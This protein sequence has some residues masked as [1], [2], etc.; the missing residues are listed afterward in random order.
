LNE[1]WGGRAAMSDSRRRCR[2]VMAYHCEQY[3]EDFANTLDVILWQIDKKRVP[4][5]LQKFPD[6]PSGYGTIHGR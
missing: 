6:I 1:I 4:F 2:W 3:P 5:E